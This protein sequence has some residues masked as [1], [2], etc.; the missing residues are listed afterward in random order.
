MR[1]NVAK[2]GT[3]AC[4]RRRHWNQGKGPQIACARIAA[5]LAS[6]PDRKRPKQA[7]PHR[8]HAMN[9]TSHSLEGEIPMD[10]DHEGPLNESEESR[11]RSTDLLDSEP[12]NS[13]P[14]KLALQTAL[15]NLQQRRSGPNVVDDDIEVDRDDEESDLEDAQNPSHDMDQPQSPHGP[16]IDE[17]SEFEFEDQLASDV[18][19]S[20]ES[21]KHAIHHTYPNNIFP[22]AGMKTLQQ[23]RR[24]AALG[25]FLSVF[26]RVLSLLTLP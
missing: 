1:S 10:I 7:P 8:K 19:H 3:S 25:E 22:K 20:H 4:S 16:S 24:L 23:S 17:E 5:V 12:A 6:L 15:L 9:S 13:N 2:V 26:A 18:S 11:E 14:S 21:L